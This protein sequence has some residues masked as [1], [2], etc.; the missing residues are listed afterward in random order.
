MEFWAK[1]EGIEG[2]GL[3]Y[4]QPHL[5]NSPGHSER[6]F[7]ASKRAKDA[8]VLDKKHVGKGSSGT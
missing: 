8:T 5:P 7:Q 2:K 6:E 1:K 3:G 4:R